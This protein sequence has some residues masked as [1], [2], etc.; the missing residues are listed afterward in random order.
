[1]AGAG[2]AAEQRGSRSQLPFVIEVDT[3]RVA[4][5]VEAAEVGGGEDP[6]DEGEFSGGPVHP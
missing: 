5:R 3:G 1:M 2:L 4:C 6:V